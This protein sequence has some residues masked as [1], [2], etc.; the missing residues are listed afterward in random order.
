MT[1][2]SHKPYRSKP[3]I[4]VRICKVLF[5][6]AIIVVLLVLSAF[7]WFNT[8]LQA[9][10]VAS[11]PI[12]ITI[13]EGETVE[14]I[15]A[16][17]ELQGIV[18][19]SLALQ[20]Y[21]RLYHSDDIIQAG[22]YEFDKTES[23]K[24]V[25]S[26]LISGDVSQNFITFVPGS[27]LGE[28]K[29]ALEERGYSSQAATTALKPSSYSSHPLV[30]EYLP[31]TADLEGYLYPDT[32]ATSKTT[33]AREVVEASLDAMYAAITPAMKASFAEKGLTVHE[34]I[35][36]ASIV[37]KEVS[38]LDEKPLVAQVFLSRLENNIALESN[39]TDP[40]PANYN[41]YEIPGLPPGP[42]SNV[43]ISSL[44]AVASPSDSDYLYF[45]TGNDCVTRFSYTLSEH[46]Q[47]QV[48]HGVGCLL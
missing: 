38:N 24:K 3:H 46:E 16:R 26:R 22:S 15:A 23:S 47:L 21:T 41:T 11:D 34:A 8:S 45:V 31:D 25:I 6:V 33:D 13:E 30:V 29:Q 10:Q 40:Y 18:K 27:R 1:F 4:A 2:H 17:L 42:L 9:P 14:Q 35:I 48:D 5:V 19:S 32:Y 39:A 44:E 20:L 37:E 43:S 7:I 12:D 28:I 36:L